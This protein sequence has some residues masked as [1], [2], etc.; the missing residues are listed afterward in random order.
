MKII[1]NDDWNLEVQLNAAER[2]SYFDRKQ[3][4]KIFPTRYLWL[5][6]LASSFYKEWK[7]QNILQHQIPLFYLLLVISN[8]ALEIYLYS[9]ILGVIT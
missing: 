1:N 3:V 2:F 8:G 5:P 9:E 7:C 6:V 4:L